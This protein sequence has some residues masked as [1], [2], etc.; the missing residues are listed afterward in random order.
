[1]TSATSNLLNQHQASLNQQNHNQTN[2]LATKASENQSTF[3]VENYVVS[4]YIDNPYLITGKK[5][6]IRMYVLVTSF[7]PLTVWMHREGFA[8]FSNQRFSLENIDNAI[9]HLTNVAIQKTA[10][11]YDPEK[12][13]KWSL[14]SLRTYLNHKHGIEKTNHIFNQMSRIV[15]RSLQSVKK[16]YY[17]R[18]TL[19]RTLRLRFNA[20]R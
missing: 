12:G 2:T 11:D 13:A 8:R 17:Q 4:R 18:Q 20:G 19:L 3:V 6:D 5:F 16:N 14:E 10:A 7:S 15:I 9:V 1:M